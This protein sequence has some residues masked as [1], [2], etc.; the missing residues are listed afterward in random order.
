[1]TEQLPECRLC[2]TTKNNVELSVHVIEG[3]EPGQ[4]TSQVVML[5]ESC[6]EDEQ[7]DAIERQIK[8]AELR[9]HED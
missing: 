5:C 4:R 2:G 3:P 7:D 6:W 1:M 8:Q 9:H